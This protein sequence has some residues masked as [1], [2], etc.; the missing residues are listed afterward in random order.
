MEGQIASREGRRFGFTIGSA[1]IVLG[2]ITWWRDHEIL[3]QFLAGTGSLLFLGAL[4]TP[5]WLK[6]IERGWMFSDL[7]LSLGM[8]GA[9]SIVRFRAAIKEPEELSYLFL[10]IAI[11]LRVGADQRVITILSIYNYSINYLFEK[12][13]KAEARIQQSLFLQFLAGRLKK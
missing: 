5:S 13:Q 8:V 4:I 9:L 10:T 6:P 11:G 12:L 7:V 2:G 1:F 3:S